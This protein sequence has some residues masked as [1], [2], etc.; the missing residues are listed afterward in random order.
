MCT[1]TVRLPFCSVH[2][3]IQYHCRST[4]VRILYG[5]LSAVSMCIISIT[6]D[7]HV[8]GY[9]TA[10]FLQCPCAQYSRIASPPPKHSSVSCQSRRCIAMTP[11]VYPANPVT[12]SDSEGRRGHILPILP[13]FPIQSFLHHSP[14]P[15]HTLF[16][17][18]T[19]PL[20]GARAGARAHTHTQTSLALLEY[21]RFRRTHTLAR[22]HARTH[23]HTHTNLALPEYALVVCRHDAQGRVAAH[24]AA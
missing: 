17:L 23:F 10:S 4:C 2:V 22:A 14:A 6:V 12:A 5:F 1:D 8:Y 16:Q 24:A 19:H 7:P 13:S 15:G 9:C 21:A 20:A 11:A 18:H 3:H